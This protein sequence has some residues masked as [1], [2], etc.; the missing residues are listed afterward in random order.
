VGALKPLLGAG[1]ALG[2]VALGARGLLRRPLPRPGLVRVAGLDDEVEILRDRWGVP[3]IYARTERDLFFANGVVHVEDR[4]WQMELNRRAATGRLSE[5]FGAVTLEADRMLRRFGFG[6]T[7]R[8]E[9][10]TLDP[11]SRAVLESYAAGVNWAIE[12]RP[13]PLEMLL[14]R[15]R[16]EPWTP[17]D[18]LAWAKL[19]GWSL[20]VNWDTEL[21]RMQLASGIGPEL[22]A[23]L[24]PHYPLGGWLSGQGEALGRAAGPLLES[25]AR[26]QELT[27]LGKLGGSNAW[28]VAPSRSDSGSAILANDVHLAPQMPSV[29][30]ELSLDARDAA[31]RGLHVVG[32]SL[33]GIPGIVTGHNGRIGWGYTASLVDV[34]D[35]YVERLHPDD[36]RRFRRGDGWEEAEVVVEEI[37]VKGQPRWQ[38]EEVLVSSNGPVVTPLVPGVDVVLSLRAVPLEVGSSFAP[39]IRLMRATGLSDFRAAMA[40]WVTPSLGVV[41]ADVEGNI[42]FQIVGRVPRRDRGDG[43]VPAPGWDPAYAWQGYIPFDELPG[44]FNPPEGFV[45][46]ANNRPVGDDYR[47]P[48]G[49]DW[50]DSYR[51]GRIVELLRQRPKH[52]PESFRAIQLDVTSGA[53]GAL[54]AAVARILGDEQPIDPLEREALRLL[55]QWDG[56][57]AADSAPAA[58]YELFR[59]KLLRFLYSPQLGDLVDLYLGAPAHGRAT[60][61]SFAWRASSRLIGALADPDEPERRGHRGLSWRDL[62][63]ICLGEAVSELRQRL[64]EEIGCWSWG[65]LHRLSIEHPIARNRPLRRLLNR[66][67]YPVGGDIDTPL[68]IA[69]PAY[70]GGAGP[71]AWVPSHRLIVDFADVAGARSMHTTGQSGQPG[72]R[73]YD[74]FLPMWLRGEYHPLLWERADVEEQ[75]ES[76]TRLLPTDELWPRP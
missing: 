58:L 66:G 28:A 72:S 48:I 50:C 20:T 6:R 2:G 62:I 71:I 3:H 23:E 51:I 74:D 41:Y 30:Y 76:E 46:T 65:A 21:A 68:Q 61:S 54:I 75:I 13:R 24:E 29:W 70:R 25:Y 4:L 43:T 16:P 18:T 53:A 1:L 52:S 9:L 45:A 35:L 17:L 69:A 14:L 32:A 33:A 57:L 40:D 64:G 39:G 15:H 27:G 5:L 10:E 49:C 44:R 11:E 67:P 36:P 60:V 42:G 38:T 59:T 73:H 7:A 19:M 37:R 26:L 22:A 47:Y 34:Q 8:R 63:L 56:R 55:R 12:T 31:G